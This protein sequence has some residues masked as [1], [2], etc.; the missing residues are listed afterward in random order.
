MAMLQN[1]MMTNVVVL[2][3]QKVTLT[4]VSLQRWTLTLGHASMSARRTILH[5]DRRNG[6]ARSAMHWRHRCLQDDQP[7]A[8]NWQLQRIIFTV[9]QRQRQSRKCL[10]FVFFKSGL[11]PLIA[12]Y[13]KQALHNLFQINPLSHSIIYNES[14]PR[15]MVC[16]KSAQCTRVQRAG[17][18]TLHSI[19]RVFSPMV[20]VQVTNKLTRRHNKTLTSYKID[21]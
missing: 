14:R 17:Y 13:K 19:C 16:S 15:D 5:G 12:I 6:T 7:L 20:T 11:K 4:M 2:S 1:C 3:E 21:V 10:P 8:L 18:P 9:K